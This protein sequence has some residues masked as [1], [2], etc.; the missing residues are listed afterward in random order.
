[1]LSTSRWGNVGLAVGIAVALAVWAMHQAGWLEAWDGLFYD[2]LL[3]LT[4][5]WH[6][7]KPKVLLLRLSREDAWSDAE[8]IKTLETLEG[9]GARAIAIDFLP[10]RNSP[11][12]FQRAGSLKNVVFGRELRPDPDNPDVLRL[13]PWP[14]AAHD[15]DLPFGVV[16]LPSS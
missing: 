10:Y 9:L 14:A 12:F 15:L 2:R 5:R 3:S 13:E 11:E 4:T 16:F 6:D 1:M 7:P 8:A